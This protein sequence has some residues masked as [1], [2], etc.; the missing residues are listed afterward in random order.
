[1]NSI[2]LPRCDLSGLGPALKYEGSGF[3]HYDATMYSPYNTKVPDYSD[4]CVADNI[5]SLISTA[6]AVQ[7]GLFN[8][9]EALKRVKAARVNALLPRLVD[10][11]D[12]SVSSCALTPP[13]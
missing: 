9:I 7:E 2:E 8:A 3:S 1:M 11:D 13:D 6:L 5:S 4:P 12:V 10:I